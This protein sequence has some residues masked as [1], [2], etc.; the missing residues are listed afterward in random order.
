MRLF[1]RGRALLLLNVAFVAAV[2]VSTAIVR[3]QT[4]TG[5]AQGPAQHRQAAEIKIRSDGKVF[6]PADTN[7]CAW[8]EDGRAIGKDELGGPAEVIDLAGNCD[9]GYGFHYYPRLQKLVAVS[10]IVEGR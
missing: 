5:E 1:R 4:G 10:P 6:L 9:L 8:N 3:T 2:V 7:G